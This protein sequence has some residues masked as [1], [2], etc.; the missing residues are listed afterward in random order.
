MTV[1][2]NTIIKSVSLP[3]NHR[4]PL[5]TCC[6]AS[7]PWSSR[8]TE[9]WTMKRSDEEQD[10]QENSWY[11]ESNIKLTTAS[12]SLCPTLSPLLFP[13]QTLPLLSCHYATKACSQKQPPS[14]TALLLFK[15]TASPPSAPTDGWRTQMNETETL[16]QS[17][18][19]GFYL[20]K[21]ADE[22]TLKVLSGNPRDL[23]L[24]VCICFSGASVCTEL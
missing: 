5:T 15:Q 12:S 6:R 20:V 14:L 23:Y 16:S 2:E 11:T 18:P 10:S 9:S 22:Q 24:E 3:A 8:I 1:W 7:F 19:A 13:V 4:E 21:N 17:Q